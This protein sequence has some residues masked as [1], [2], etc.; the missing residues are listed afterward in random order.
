MAAG[1]AKVDFFGAG[2][3]RRGESRERKELFGKL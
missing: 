3:D 2:A 1:L